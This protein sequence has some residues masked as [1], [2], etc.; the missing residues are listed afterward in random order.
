MYR[1]TE[2]AESPF[3][4]KMKGDFEQAL[5]EYARHYVE[6]IRSGNFP[7]AEICFDQMFDICLLDHLKAG[8]RFES[9]SKLL[10]T[11]ERRLLNVLS[12]EELENR[13]EFKERLDSCRRRLFPRGR[14]TGVFSVDPKWLLKTGQ[15]PA[16]EG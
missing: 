6:S 3:E 14:S 15:Y 4:L 1:K 13:S 2:E 7:I 5:R 8:S 16:P 12:L 10:E 11:I 9:K